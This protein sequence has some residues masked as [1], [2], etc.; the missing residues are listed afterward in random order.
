MHGRRM[1]CNND[2]KQVSKLQV[3]RITITQESLDVSEKDV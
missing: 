1:D 2:K 3:Y